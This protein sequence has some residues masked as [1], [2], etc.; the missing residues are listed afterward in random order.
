VITSV[1]TSAS[2]NNSDELE[3]FVEL[4]FPVAGKYLPADH[5]YG[6]YAAF[7]HVIPEG[8]EIAKLLSDAK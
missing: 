7:V 6:L 5:N 4:K 8:V 1:R 2:L 3:P